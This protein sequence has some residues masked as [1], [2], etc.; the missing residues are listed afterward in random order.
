[1]D[2]R[3]FLK[4]LAG[5][6]AGLALSPKGVSAKEADCS[7]FVGILVD[8]TRCIGCRSCEVACAEAHGLPVPE[9]GDE[10]VFRTLRKPS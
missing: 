6:M 8:T 3:T 4:T 5:G 1:M 7:E 10:S 9:V 2:R